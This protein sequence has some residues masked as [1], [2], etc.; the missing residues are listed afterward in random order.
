M[1]WLLKKKNMGFFF[2][3]SVKF[4]Y[5]SGSASNNKWDPDLHKFVLDPPHWFKIKVDRL[6]VQDPSKKCS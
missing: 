2:T 1:I 4:L 6:K 3:N 5:V